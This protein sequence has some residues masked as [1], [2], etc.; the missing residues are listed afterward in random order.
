MNAGFVS[1]SAPD[2]MEGVKKYLE[3]Q[4]HQ[5]ASVFFGGACATRHPVPG[6][7]GRNDLLLG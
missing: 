5:V 6:K 4:H 7:S 2:C 1:L 3:Q